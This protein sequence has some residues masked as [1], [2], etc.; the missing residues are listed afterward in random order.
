M[1]CQIGH[2][3]LTWYLQLFELNW[4]EAFLLT[5]PAWNNNA[6]WWLCKL[7]CEFGNFQ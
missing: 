4:L 6:A 5:K 7:G 1:S 3:I 2:L